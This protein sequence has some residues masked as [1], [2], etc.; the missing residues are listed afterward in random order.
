MVRGH[1]PDGACSRDRR[2]LRWRLA[3]EPPVGVSA[4]RGVPEHLEE[5]A[6][7]G[8]ELRRRLAEQL[9]R[10]AEEELD[11]RRVAELREGLLQVRERLRMRAP[12]VPSR[13]T[14]T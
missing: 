4:A 5:R 11:L 8:A 14:T 13:A 2:M 3:C 9:A 12:S 6:P 1:E 10:T 7:H